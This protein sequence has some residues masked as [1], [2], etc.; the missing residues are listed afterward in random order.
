MGYKFLDNNGLLYFWSK[1]KTLVNTKLTANVAITGGTKTKITYD[2]NGL[3]T[4]GADATTADIND[5]LDKRYITDAQKTVLG[6]TSGTNTGN[7]TITSMGTLVNGAAAKATP[8]DADLIP[9]VNSADANKIYKLTWANLKAA[10]KAFNDT[11]YATTGHNHDAA[12]QALDADLT[13]IAALAGT[14]GL[15]KKTAANTWALDTNSYQAADADLTSIAA[16]AGTTG[17]LKKTAANTWVLD[18]AAYLTVVPD[19]SA[20]YV[21]VASKGQ[22]NGWCPL[23][24]DVLIPSQYLPSYVDDVMECLIVQTAANTPAAPT[25]CTTGQHYY[26]YSEGK[27][28]T[29]TGTNTW[30]A[31]VVPLSDKIYVDVAINTSYR[32][33]TSQMVAIT[34]GDMVTITNA[35]IDIVVA[36]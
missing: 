19:L 24:A 9:I 6:N 8:V 17:L 15:L 22:A 11:L 36:T 14:T 13:S 27:I 33:G 1:I 5:S 3:V 28:H 34:S 10:L 31:G 7:E 29:A 35:E 12:Y 20:T 23:G 2:A 32:W 4:G 26:N 25:T 21:T 16:L 30:D 18:T